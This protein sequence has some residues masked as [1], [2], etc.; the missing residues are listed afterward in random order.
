[1]RRLSRYLTWIAAFILVSG[2]ILG[3]D[4]WELLEFQSQ[5][6]YQVTTGIV[7]MVLVLFQW[8]L[9]LGRVIFQRTGSQWGR[10]IDWH[11]RSAVLLPFA[12]LAHSLTLG[13]GILAAL[14]LSL[15]GAAHF[16]SLMNGHDKI[17]E[18][19]PYHVGLSALTLALALIHAY[20]V[21]IFR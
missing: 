19:L 5:D 9:T 18:Y 13:W 21:L 17:K 2:S 16:G 12:L 4:D 3:L 8:G 11:L 20:T 1:M 15:L 6:A 7:I 14:P 10:W